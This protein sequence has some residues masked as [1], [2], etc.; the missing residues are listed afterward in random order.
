[1]RFGSSLSSGAQ[2]GDATGANREGAVSQEVID[3]LK[4]QYG[5]DKPMMT[6]YWIWLKNIG[7]LD[8]GESFTY[9]EPVVDVI[10][11]KFPVSLQFGVASLILT[12]LVCILLGLPKQSLM[13][14][15]LISEFSCSFWNVRYSWFYVGDSAYSISC[16]W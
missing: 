1:M 11:S 10:I 5:F 16:F 6:R 14:Q 2:S 8:L 3:A 9:E 13:E 4:K 7:T 15:G 12:Y